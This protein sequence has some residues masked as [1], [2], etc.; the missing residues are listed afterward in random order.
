M[1]LWQL[2]KHSH[3]KEIVMVQLVKLPDNPVRDWAE[4]S[5]EAP[6]RGF[7]FRRRVF[8]GGSNGKNKFRRG[9]FHWLNSTC[10]AGTIYHPGSSL[11]LF[12]RYPFIS[13][14]APVS[15]VLAISFSGISELNI[16]VMA[17]AIRE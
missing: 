13:F 2:I 1:C 3:F 4:G 12:L 15:R 10:I 17:V 9:L 11:L 8:S 5:P 7:P 6:I 14:C 16:H